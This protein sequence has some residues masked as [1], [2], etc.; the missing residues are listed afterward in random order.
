MSLLSTVAD[1]NEKS[2]VHNISKCGVIWKEKNIAS[3]FHFFMLNKLIQRRMVKNA[4]S[5]T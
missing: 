2:H 5:S 1:F 4:C 3:V